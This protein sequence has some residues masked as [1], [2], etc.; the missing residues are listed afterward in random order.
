MLFIVPEK[1]KEDIQIKE[2]LRNI[3]KLISKWLK[4]TCYD[5]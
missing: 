3:M 2:I 5:K 1:I 4:K